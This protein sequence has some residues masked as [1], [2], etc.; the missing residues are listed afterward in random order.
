V[1]RVPCYS[2]DA[3]DDR[4]TAA[5]IWWLICVIYALIVFALWVLANNP[6]KMK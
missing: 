1:V 2:K 3:S 6:R 5:M 4:G